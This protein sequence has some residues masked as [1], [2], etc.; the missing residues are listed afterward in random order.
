M[1]LRKV[2]LKKPELGCPYS[3]PLAIIQESFSLQIIP[4]HRLWNKKWNKRGEVGD[5]PWWSPSPWLASPTTSSPDLA[6]EAVGVTTPIEAAK[7]GLGARDTTNTRKIKRRRRARKTKRTRKI[8]TGELKVASNKWLILKPVFSMLFCLSGPPNILLLATPLILTP[9]SVTI[10]LTENLRQS[11]RSPNTAT[12][13]TTVAILTLLHPPGKFCYRLFLGGIHLSPCKWDAG[14]TSFGNLKTSLSILKASFNILRI[15]FGIFIRSCLG[16][17]YSMPQTVWNTENVSKWTSNVEL[18]FSTA[19]TYWII[20]SWLTSNP[21]ISIWVHTRAK[22][23]SFSKCHNSDH[24]WGCEKSILQ[25]QP[26][27]N[28]TCL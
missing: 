21:K 3:R 10:G 15:S 22:I 14:Q 4:L 24:F 17:L 5:L 28:E 26:D 12:S 7:G 18:L 2:H 23:Y 27:H 6:A 1:D 13:Q 25:I 19:S 8:G 20:Y 11:T 9:S 16:F